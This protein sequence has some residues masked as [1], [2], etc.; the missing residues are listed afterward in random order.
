VDTE[1]QISVTEIPI[2]LS[3][4][5]DRVFEDVLSGVTFDMNVFCNRDG[6][7][8][9]SSDHATVPATVTITNGI[10]TFNVTCNEDSVITASFGTATDDCNVILN[11]PDAHVYIGPDVVITEPNITLQLAT[12]ASRPGTGT[13]SVAPSTGLS[14]PATVTFALGSLEQQIEGTLT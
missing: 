6:I 14:F 12:I 11:L 5:A 1:C 9:L 10:G 13:I 8:N 2:I 7:C 3:L 4:G